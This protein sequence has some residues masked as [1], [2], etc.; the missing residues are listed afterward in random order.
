M[1]N[2]FFFV[3]KYNYCVLFINTAI[4]LRFFRLDFKTIITVF[5]AT[6]ATKFKK[7]F[8]L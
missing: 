6:K 3:T 5:K 7:K 2:T 4:K 8:K 1:L